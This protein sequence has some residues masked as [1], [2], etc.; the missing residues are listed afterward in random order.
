MLTGAAFSSLVPYLAAVAGFIALRALFQYLRD[1]VS[2]ETAARVKEG[3]HD[4]LYRHAL[5]LGPGHFNQERTG[6]VLVSLG[7]GVERLQVFY[8]QFLPQMVVAGV[9]PV[10]IFFLMA[11]F[12]LVIGLIFVVFALLTLVATPLFMLLTEESSRRRRTSYGAFNADFL[13]SIQGIATLKIFG[14]SRSQG[15]HLADRARHLYRTTMSVLATNMVSVGVTTFGILGGTACALGWGALKVSAGE[16]EV[17]SL[18]VILIMG[19]EIFR[20]MRELTILYHQ[21]INAMAAAEGIFELLE[22]PVTVR[23]PA[24]AEAAAGA[25][26]EPEI[27]FEDVSFAY[28]E[29]SR[30]ALRDVSLEL[31]AGEKLGVVGPSGAGK[32][33]LVSLMLRFGDPQEGR[34]LLGGR[35]IRTIPLAVL[36]RHVAVVAQDMYLFYGTIADNLRMA[37]PDATPGG[38]RGRGPGGQHPRVYRRAFR[39]LRHRRGRAGRAALRRR[40]PAHRHRPG[41]P[42]GRPDP[43]AGRGAVERGR[44][45]RGGDQRGA[46][47]AHG[48]AHHADHRPPAVERHPRGPHPGAGTGPGGGDRQPRGAAEERRH[49][50]PA[51]GRPG[52]SRR[53]RGVGGARG[54]G[55]GGGGRARGSRRGARRPDRE[56]PGAAVGLHRAAAAGGAGAAFPPQARGI[57]LR[58]GALSGL[59]GRGSARPAH[60]WWGSSSA[61]RTS[62]SS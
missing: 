51:H 26:F 41:D 47:Q 40:A 45:E 44:P 8:G 30:P 62:R 19:A 27:R 29:G 57:V 55:H 25:S 58:R 60:C 49:L 31:R 54:P 16:L 48:G 22:A 43:G 50:R 3:L 7:E 13:D 24:A 9:A 32:S 1:M 10:L 4:K 35:D 15:E 14:R 53:R 37:K 59:G 17:R 36:R 56:R 33:T 34:V 61:A 23:E 52:P 18:I 39:G 11:S 46:A 21:G 38:D 12:D 6:D 42:E 20:P 5:D 2:Q 28:Q